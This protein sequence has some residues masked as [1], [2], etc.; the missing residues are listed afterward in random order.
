[1]AFRLFPK[2]KRLPTILGILILVVGVVVTTYLSQRVQ[3]FFLKA[4]P[5][6]TP[7]QVKISN[8]TSKT[9]T[10]SW[11]TPDNPSSGYIRYGK[12]VSLGKFS[13]D[14]RDQKIEALGQYSVHHV[15]VGGLDPQTTYYFKLVSQGK[16]S[17]QNGSPYSVTT[18]PM[19]YS[20]PAL[21]PTYGLV[22]EENGKP[23]KEGVVYV[24]ISNSNSVSTLI[25]L[26]GNW[27]VPLSSLSSPDP[28]K[29]FKINAGDFEE[30]FVQGSEKTSKVVTNLEGNAPVP[31]ITL[32]RDDD[33]RATA[34]SQEL[35]QVGSPA[36]AP[37]FSLTQPA[38]DAAIPGQPLFRGTGVPGK[39]VTIKVESETSLV[40]TVT[41]NGSGDWSWQ[42]PDNL[43]PGEHTV[44]VTSTD[45]QGKLQTIIR[46]FIILASGTQVTEAATP[47]ATPIITFGPSPTLTPTPPKTS[48]TPTLTL[49]PTPTRIIT[50]TATFVLSPTP[51][52]TSAA[53]PESGE[54]LLTLI[55]ATSGLIFIFL[56]FFFLKSEAI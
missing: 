24:T 4:E 1:M 42:A 23:P 55:L 52:A 25:E 19:N 31:T 35:P 49:T 40:E 43:P 9:F 17:D 39:T 26:S 2:E 5:T 20:S 46:K 7:Q 36:L 27:L 30:I 48:P 12:S 37:N 54:F 6:I 47:S 22:L 3:Q 29:P 13:L 38:T 21:A 18:L 32:G 16:E 33:F 45:N 8:V 28:K 50:P 10:V 51:Q 44:T 15:N 34:A 56:G 14:E 53:V 11:V 41:V